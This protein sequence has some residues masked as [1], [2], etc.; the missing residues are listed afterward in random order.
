MEKGKLYICP[1][2]IGNLEDITL[3]VLRILR[4]VDYIAAEDTRQ[5]IKLL[6]HFEINKN[7]TSY[8]EHNKMKKGQGILEDLME[9]KQVA[10]VSDAGMPGISDPGEELIKD[11]IEHH[12]EVEVLPGA[13]AAILALVASGLNASQFSFEGFLSRDKKKR[14]E[15]LERIKTEDRTLIFYE[16]PHRLK[17]TL[18]DCIKILGKRRAVVGRELTKRF[19]EFIRGELQEVLAHFEE[20]PPKGEIV[21]MIEGISQE[22][23]EALEKQEYQD[24]SIKDHVVQLLNSG[25]DKK[26]AIKEVSKIRKIPKREVYQEAIDL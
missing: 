7:L 20:I 12:I 1:T 8:H 26:E 13:T 2:P 9:G 6:N 3:R 4:E 19:E 25:M 11:C 23:Y 22:E 15:R 24:L 18:E 16:A 10:L 17:D 5:T 14:R 21:L